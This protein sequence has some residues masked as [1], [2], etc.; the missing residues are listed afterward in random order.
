MNKRVVVVIAV[1]GVLLAGVIGSTLNKPQS[2]ALDSTKPVTSITKQIRPTCD[3]TSV[4]THCSIDGVKYASYI[5]HAATPEISHTE[6]VTTYKQ[7][8]TDYCTLCN[9][10]TYSPSCAT[11]SG[12]CSHHEG[13]A[14]WNAPVYSTVPQNSTK[15][16][17]DSPAK[18]EY[19]EKI[20]E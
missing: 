4:T 15:T 10:G 5:Y 11:S 16:V 13:V 8:I 20:T 9:D 2:S 6:T 3:C 19:Y 12:A 18:G 17:V 14:Q 7:E 1:A